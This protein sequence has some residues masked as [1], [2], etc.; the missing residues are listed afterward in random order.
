MN[1]IKLVIAYDGGAFYGWQTTKTGP[2]VEQTLQKT[3]EK[4]LNHPVLLQ[5]A[6]RT[7]RG[8][9]AYGQVVNFFSL[10]IPRLESLNALLPPT[11]RVLS[12]ELMPSDFHPTLCAV[13]KE[14]LFN[15]D[16]SSI[17]LPFSRHDSWHLPRF[18]DLE[19]MQKASVNFLGEHDFSALCNT[20]EGR[21]YK[22]KIREIWWIDI[23]PDQ[24]FIRFAVAGNHFLYKMARNIVGTLAYVGLGKLSPCAIPSILDGKLR[25]QAGICAPP[26]GLALNKVFYKLPERYTGSL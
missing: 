24:N 9:H 18:L 7:D 5:A 14:Y 20:N 23:L 4:I 12:L 11:I 17:Q 2:S 8:V 21:I 19:A 16:M 25:A 10:K 1:N 6:S 26:Q 3:L 22:D 15:I 13:G